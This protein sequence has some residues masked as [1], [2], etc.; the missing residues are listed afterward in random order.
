M[1]RINETS[2]NDEHIDKL[3]TDYAR[4][5]NVNVTSWYAERTQAGITVSFTV[6]ENDLIFYIKYK[7]SIDSV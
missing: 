4:K 2:Y 3:L 1:I 5:I 6:F 7:K